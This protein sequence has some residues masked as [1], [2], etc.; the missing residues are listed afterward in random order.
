M[1]RAVDVGRDVLA[2]VVVLGRGQNQP[3]AGALGDLDRLQHALALGEAAE[4]Q[5]VVV[6]LL[7]GR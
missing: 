3:H 2:V 1:W 4:E 7:A 6:G 5:Q